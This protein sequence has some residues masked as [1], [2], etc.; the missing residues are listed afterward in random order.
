MLGLDPLPERTSL[1]AVTVGILDHPDFT[2]EKLHFQSQPG[3]YVAANLYIPK[4]RTKPLPAILYVCGHSQMK[5]NGVSTGNKT[6]YQHH[7][8]WFARNGF[9]ALAIDTIQLGEIEG[10]H[11]GTHHLNLWW[12]NSRGYTPAGVE[13]WNGIRALDYLQSRP[14]VDPS[15]LGVTGRSG[16]G[17]YSW[18]IAA[19]D[20]RI[21]AA[22]PVAG[23]TDL[24]NHVVDGVVDG[25]CDC[26]FFVN[27]HRWDFQ[28][29]AALIAPRPL[30][31]GN[32]DKDPIFPLD[33]VQRVH[34]S[35]AK[36]YKS[37]NASQHLGLLIAEGPHK[38][39]QELQVAAFRWFKRFLDDAPNHEALPATKLFKPAELRV[40][41]S[42]PA[43]QKTTTT[44]E[45]FVPKADPKSFP[46]SGDA[47]KA[48]AGEWITKIRK[49]S[50]TTWAENIPPCRFTRVQKEQQG[51]GL[52]SQYGVQTDSRQ[53]DSRIP[54]G[55]CALT[56]TGKPEAVAAFYS[57][58][59]GK[60]D[61]R[62]KSIKAVEVSVAEDAEAGDLHQSTTTKTVQ[63]SGVLYL[64]LS[65][66]GL[67]RMTASGIEASPWTTDPKEL[68]RIK[69]RYM[70]TGATLDS[71]RVYDIARIIGDLH[72]LMPE[73]PIRL[74]S[75]G[76][77]AVN[78]LYASLFSEGI[79][80]IKLRGMPR[81][82]ESMGAPDYFNILRVVDIPQVLEIAR[83][84]THV[85]LE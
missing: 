56:A 78:T 4:N 13:T 2:V 75:K 66:R 69:R 16:G 71:A 65:P 62:V 27:T 37:L 5:E 55:E 61:K 81:T 28:K 10:L 34:A 11:H 85:E 29:V 54:L 67:A 57:V 40:F 9:V 82:H 30:L 50:F 49:T 63:E 6:G 7:P 46:A 68:T 23:I 77:S 44:H 8:E 32:T 48:A 76:R 33:G 38:D 53:T 52:V 18:Y 79:E 43:D 31:I 12:W 47:W 21:K 15:R 26:M 14:E 3:L 58:A 60:P 24:R 70:L 80:S 41:G 39:I 17:A 72:R 83:T 51:A 42:I 20:T 84:R 73:A 36:V 1:N 59:T 64:T 35:A 25:H 19:V 74:S 22:V 45:W